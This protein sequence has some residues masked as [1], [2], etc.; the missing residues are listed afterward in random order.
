MYNLIFSTKSDKKFQKLDQSLQQRIMDKLE[1]FFS[2]PDIYKFSREL[3]VK[4]K[5]YRFRIGDYRVVYRLE[6]NNLIVINID[7]RKNIY[8]NF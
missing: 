7:H 4:D 3:N 2:Q 1:F 6:T 5:S 8:K